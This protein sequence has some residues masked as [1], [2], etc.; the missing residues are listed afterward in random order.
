MLTDEERALFAERLGPGA[1]VEVRRVLK[2]GVEYGHGLEG[3][4][5]VGEWSKEFVVMSQRR[6]D[7]AGEARTAAFQMLAFDFMDAA[8]HLFPSA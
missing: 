7:E 1:H 6:L 2:R 5:T 8:P 3:R 4:R